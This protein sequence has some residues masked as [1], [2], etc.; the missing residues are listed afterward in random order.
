MRISIQ[1]FG[2]FKVFPQFLGKL[3][4]PVVRSP[5]VPFHLG[6]SSD[7]VPS[8]GR[9]PSILLH[10][11]RR[12]GKIEGLFVTPANADTISHIIGNAVIRINTPTDVHLAHQVIDA[13]PHA[14]KR[15][16]TGGAAD[17]SE[18]VCIGGTRRAT[19]LAK[20]VN[21]QPQLSG[22]TTNQGSAATTDLVTKRLDIDV[23]E[24][25]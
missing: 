25:L 18:L 8:Q 4:N 16:V 20:I 12:L 10:D 15:R 22:R 13:S 2:E 1:V 21:K 6:S 19:E 3:S 7:A 17:V 24:L 9:R 14:P 23:L 5:Q 11:Y